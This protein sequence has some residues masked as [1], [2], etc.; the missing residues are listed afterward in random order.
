[1][2]KKGFNASKCISVSAYITCVQQEEFNPVK[3]LAVPGLL[4]WLQ[5]FPLL[6]TAFL[7]LPGG[8]SVTDFKSCYSFSLNFEPYLQRSLTET[9]GSEERAA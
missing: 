8:H 4:Q 9:A 1:M 5:G 6:W 7:L 3:S 2:G